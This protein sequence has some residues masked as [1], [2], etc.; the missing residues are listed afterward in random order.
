M[1]TSTARRRLQAALEV[2]I[3]PAEIASITTSLSRLI[4]AEGR[5]RG[6]RRRAVKRK[7]TAEVAPAVDLEAEF[8]MDLP[9]PTYTPTIMATAP[10]ALKVAMERQNAAPP[11]EVEPEPEAPAASRPTSGTRTM[12][13]YEPLSYWDYEWSVEMVFD[14]DLGGYRRNDPRQVCAFQILPANDVVT[15]DEYRIGSGW[16]RENEIAEQDAEQRAWDDRAKKLY[17]I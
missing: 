9:A 8:V 17:G 3:D 12:S 16:T 1:Y 11:A 5:E 13:V 10:D 4:D 2:A 15:S 6:R 14:P 7:A